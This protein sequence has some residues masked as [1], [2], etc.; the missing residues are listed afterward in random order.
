[1]NV[2]ATSG[3]GRL[4]VALLIGLLVGLDRERAEV[5][6]AREMFAGVRT[7]SLIAMAGCLPMLVVDR[8]GPWLVVAAFLAVAAIE[9]LA[10]HRAAAEGHIGAT[11]EMAGLA[12]FL[13]GALAG[14]GQLL[15]AGAGGIAVATLLV[16][17]PRLEAFSLAL[18]TTELAAVLELA[19]ITVIVLPLLPDRGYGPWA[20]LNPRDI[21]MVVVLVAGLSFAGFVAV[22]LLG[23]RRGLAI[24]GAVGG[25]VSSTAVTMAMAER[26]KEGAALER[27][28]AAATVLAGTVMALRVVVLAAAVNTGMVPRL[29]PAA[30]A[31]AVVGSFAAWWI[32]RRDTGGV[33]AAGAQIRNPFSFRTAVVFAV[34]YALVLLGSRA[35]V[36]LMGSGGLFAAAAVGSVADVD[37]VTIA[38]THMGVARADWRMPAAAASLAVVVN[39]VVKLGLAWSRGAPGFR[40]QVAV[41]LGAMAAAAAA[42]G[43][44]VLAWA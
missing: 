25:M 42:A 28:A 10:Y 26:S 33:V 21:W 44:A 17:K 16:A 29:L 5:R 35:A 23:E 43:A 20:V 2:D 12:T 27:P 6:K 11:T 7:F 1:V 9:V 31:M 24:T 19:V 34:I 13:L 4:A 39:T 14:V 37:A 41:A 15:L 38:F 36:E 40:R 32:V 18:S 30:L 3:L 22:R 8:T